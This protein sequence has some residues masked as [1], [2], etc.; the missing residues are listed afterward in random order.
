M[1]EILFSDSACGSLKI[2]AG[3]G[4]ILWHSVSI[5]VIPDDPEMLQ[6]VL[7]EEQ[8]RWA[9]AVPMNICTQNVYTLQFGLSVGDICEQYPGEKRLDVIKQLFSFYPQGNDAANELMKNS[10]QSLKTVLNRSQQGES[11]RIWYSDQ[12]DEACGFAWLMALLTDFP[13]CGDV[14]AVKL[15]EKSL[16]PAWSDVSPEEWHKY[17]GYTKRVSDSERMD[18]AQIWH[19]LKR[20]NASLRGVVNEV[21]KSLPETH[22]DQYILQALEHQPKEF[23]EARL[24]GDVLG[25]FAPGIGDAWIAQRI[26]TMIE[27]GWLVP[28]TRSEKDS[29]RYHRILQ[30][31]TIAAEEK[32]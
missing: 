8:E 11:V 32:S 4:T 16:S 2:A 14:F 30:K 13:T 17:E 28:I 27:K 24:I 7:Q 9:H 26:E 29:P 15:P 1:L 20:E 19:N 23:Q 18:A 21:L 22:Y 25:R 10:S 12:P 5:G 3:M 31:G 6:R